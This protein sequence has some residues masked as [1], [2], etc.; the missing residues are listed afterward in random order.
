MGQE[1]MES[2]M[3]YTTEKDILKA[4]STEHLVAQFAASVDRRLDLGQS[5]PDTILNQ[6]QILVGF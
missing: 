6:V 3:L 4:L 1:R 2:P 5:V